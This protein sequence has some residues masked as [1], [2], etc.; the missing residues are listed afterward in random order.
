MVKS[1]LVG[2][3]ELVNVASVAATLADTPEAIDDVL[4]L[5][6]ADGVDR[7]DRPAGIAERCGLLRRLVVLHVQRLNDKQLLAVQRL[8]LLRGHDVAS[9]SGEEHGKP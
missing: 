5:A 4:T 2:V 3:R 1:Q 8:V 6:R 9:D 7:H